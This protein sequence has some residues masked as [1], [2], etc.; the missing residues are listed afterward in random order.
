MLNNVQL[1]KK[2]LEALEFEP[3]LDASRIAVATSD[4]VVTLT[5]QVWTY[6]EKVAAERTVKRLVGVKGIATNLEV[7]LAGDSRR[8]DTDLATAAVTALEWDVQVPNQRLQVRVADGWVTLEGSVDW[9]YQ[10][11]AAY[12]AVHNLTGVRGVTNL[13]SL[14]RKVIPGDI[15]S[16]IEGALKRNA[17]LEARGIQIQATGGKVVIEGKVHSWSEREEAEGAVWS[18]PGVTEVVDH[19]VVSA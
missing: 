2:V 13:I 15:K 16:R 5:G 1:Q 11:E 12:R 10:R 17:E 7:R 19:L 18:A 14:A 8:T 3:S 6:A 9:N 4:G